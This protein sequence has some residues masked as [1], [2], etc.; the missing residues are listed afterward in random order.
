MSLQKDLEL[1]L[2]Y[3]ESL[4]NAQSQLQQAQNNIIFVQNENERL[5]GKL[6]TTLILSVV[7]VIGIIFFS[8]LNIN[9]EEISPVIMFLVIS[10]IVFLISI[11]QCV[12]T[13]YEYDKYKHQKP[14]LIERYS[15][16][17]KACEQEIVYLVR[18]IEIEGLLKIVPVDYFSVAAIGFCLAQVR[19]KLAS[20]ASEAF[21][22]LDAEIKRLEHMEYLEELNNAQLEQL[23]GIRR[24]VDIN[25][26]VT[27]TELEKLNSKYN[28]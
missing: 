8:F 22:L 26:L 23:N 4:E 21:R 25:T 10:V 15:Q 19:R 27:L 28:S 7:S 1:C 17:A 5:K 11:V 24:A 12:K 20:T 9:V 18:E 2:D 16:E 3:A 14:S 6:R 13:K